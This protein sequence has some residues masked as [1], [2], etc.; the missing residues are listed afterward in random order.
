M[1]KEKKRDRS[2]GSDDTSSMTMG[3]GYVGRSRQPS[4][5]QRK[6]SVGQGG[7]VPR[8][9]DPHLDCCLSCIA[10]H[11]CFYECGCM[12]DGMFIQ[13]VCQVFNL[14]VEKKRKKDSA[15]SD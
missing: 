6:I 13:F 10:V 8:H 5:K 4:N 14:M 7:G 9:P 12:S 15:G 1:P 3:G 11:I 2:A